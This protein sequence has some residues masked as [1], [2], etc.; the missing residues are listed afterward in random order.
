MPLSSR[1]AAVVLGHDFKR[2]GLKAEQVDHATYAACAVP[3]LRRF[4]LVR[5]GGPVWMAGLQGTRRV[6]FF[7]FD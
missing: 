4:H 3:S 2:M 5:R 1:R 7:H 6:C